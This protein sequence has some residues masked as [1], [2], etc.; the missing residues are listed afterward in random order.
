MLVLGD[1]VKVNARR[2][3]TQKALMMD[4]RSVTFNE[5]NRFTNKLT[6]GLLS[7]GLEPG[8]RVGIWS[9]NCIEYVLIL[10]AIWSCGGISVPI[11]FRFRKEEAAYILRNSQP[12]ILFHAQDLVSLVEEICSRQIPILPISISGPHIEKGKSLTELME[13]ESDDEIEFE[14][15]P[16]SPAIIIYTSGTTGVPKGVIFSHAKE[17][18]DITSSS[19]ETDVKHEDVALLN[20]PLFHNGGLSLGLM[21]FLL[22]GSTCVILGGSFDLD[23]FLSTIERFRITVVN[24]VPTMLARLVNHP[25]IGQ[26]DLTSLK[27]IIYGSSPIIESVLKAALNIFKA[28]FY[29]TYGQTETCLS[30]VLKP[31]D[32]FTE[33]TRFTGRPLC[34]VNL[35]VVDEN[36]LDVKVGEVG[37]I[38]VRQKPLGMDGYYGMEEATRETI[39]DGWIH[40]GDLARVEGG[41]Y[42]T[43]VDRLR[44][45]IISGGENIYC[46]EIENVIMEHPGVDEVA[47]FGVPD[48]EWGE[49]VCVAMVPK[50]GVK[51]TEKEIVDHCASR[52][53]GY[54]KPK[55]IE[56]RNELPKNAAGKTL[57][58]VLKEEY[59]TAKNN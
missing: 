39:R 43:I 41:A 47:V 8:E 35:R 36:G 18:N 38:I 44:D 2:Y 37:E 19:M 16:L 11:N 40:T 24:V 25:G 10:F 51:I 23:L 7:L 58:S 53:A 50:E 55:R 14:P 57:K 13:K 4:D 21:Q 20:M 12:K 59:R 26:Y 32:H 27:K 1:I 31:G 3:P 46:K 22:H 33:R 6:H 34:R 28:D 48:K 45:I 17:L 9:R 15:D 5:M 29:Q 42:Y 54:K 52:L 30:L 49:I 56:F